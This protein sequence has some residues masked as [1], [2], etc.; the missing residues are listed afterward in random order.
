MGESICRTIEDSHVVIIR[1]KDS[2]RTVCSARLEE[3]HVIDY[4]RPGIHGEVGILAKCTRSLVRGG[5]VSNGI[6][7]VE[8]TSDED[9]VNA[10]N[11]CYRAFDRQAVGEV[12]H[13]ICWTAFSIRSE[14]MVAS[15]II[16]VVPGG[17]GQDI[18]QLE[19]GEV[20]QVVGVVSLE[21]EKAVEV[22]SMR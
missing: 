17:S 11:G 8:S 18:P 9:I 15:R 20:G 16:Y 12:N 6:F 19:M 21:P 2:L 1:A 22:G 14:H 13:N 7:A 4:P 10:G 5:Q 3:V